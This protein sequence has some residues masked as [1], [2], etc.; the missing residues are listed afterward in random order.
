MRA[1]VFH[2]GWKGKWV[3]LGDAV[4]G[5]CGVRFRCRELLEGGACVVICGGMEE[6]GEKEGAG[7][8]WSGSCCLVMGSSFSE[9]INISLRCLRGRNEAV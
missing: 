7:V 1:A 2:R 9:L 6:E 3:G 8:V 5:G 4:G